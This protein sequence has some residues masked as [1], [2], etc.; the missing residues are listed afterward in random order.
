MGKPKPPERTSD[1]KFTIASLRLDIESAREGRTWL[2]LPEGFRARENGATYPLPS[3][4]QELQTLTAIY[5]TPRKNDSGCEYLRRVMK[6]YRTK[7]GTRNSALL[8]AGRRE[9]SIRNSQHNYRSKARE[10]MVEARAEVDR[11]KEEA[12]KAI[13][14]LTDLF[15]LGR[16][17]LKGQ[18]QAYLDAKPVMHVDSEGNE[19]EGE[20]ID[21][22]AFRECF[23]MVTQAVK[24]LGLPSD[25]RE[26]ASQAILEEAAAALK[27]TRDAVSLAPGGDPEIEH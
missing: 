24:G 17:G 10:C 8:D 26:K 16:A 18:I 11:V 15:D 3:R 14:S 12:D 21:A 4:Y 22:K 23:R 27:A 19:V 13:A 6:K 5:I 2:L 25:Q 1:G 20:R 9:E 7:Q